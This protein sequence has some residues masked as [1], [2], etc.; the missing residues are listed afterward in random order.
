[1]EPA[2]G[3]TLRP[4]I[5]LN[6]DR[7]KG[8]YQSVVANGLGEPVTFESSDPLVVAQLGMFAPQEFAAD[9]RDWNFSYD[10]TAS[11][12]LVPDLL[13]HATYVRSFKPGGVSPNG[14]P[15]DSAGQP[16]LAA[17][18]FTTDIADYQALVS[19]GSPGVLR[20][21]LANAEAV[22]TKGVAADFSGRPSTRF[23]AYANVAFNN[24]TYRRLPLGRHLHRWRRAC[25]PAVPLSRRQRLRPVRMGPQRMLRELLRAASGAE[26][27]Y[28]AYC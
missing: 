17:A 16:I 22:R 1:M 23:N 9:Y 21:C 25:E 7:E 20:G 28:R 6:H 24:A 13:A 19:N 5:R 14:V 10:L 8:F 27:Q 11:Y 18:A 4:G 15:S 26:R 2:K 12:Q 3:L